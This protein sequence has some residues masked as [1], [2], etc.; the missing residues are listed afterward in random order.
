MNLL[1]EAINRDPEFS[2][3]YLEIARNTFSEKEI[4]NMC[5]RVLVLE[6]RSSPY[7]LEALDILQSRIDSVPKN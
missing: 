3:A 4:I 1:Y 7:A 2:P 6:D 5:S